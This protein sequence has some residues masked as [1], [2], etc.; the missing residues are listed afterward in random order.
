MS[1]E[2]TIVL[3]VLGAGGLIALFYVSHS[4]E[5]QR[6]EKALLIA[7]LSD[8]AIR[9]QRI[10]DS[11]PAPYIGKDIQLLLLGQIKASICAIICWIININP[12][13]KI[14]GNLMHIRLCMGDCQGLSWLQNIL[15]KEKKNTHLILAQK[16][17]TEN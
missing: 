2:L 8:Y 11:I 10:L 6:R 9:L 12:L 3:S 13:S 16:V 15:A 1:T 7:R 5:K 17:C 4:I 14:V